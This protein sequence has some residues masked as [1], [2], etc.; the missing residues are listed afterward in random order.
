MLGSA[1]NHLITDDQQ[2]AM[3]AFSQHLSG[4]DV[5]DT[6]FRLHPFSKVAAMIHW[7]VLTLIAARMNERQRAHWKEVYGHGGQGELVQDKPSIGPK[8]F[9]AHFHLDRTTDLAGLPRSSSLEQVLR[10]AQA[11]GLV[12]A[13]CE[14][15]LIGTCA[16]FCDP[17]TYP[18]VDDL[19]HFPSNMALAIGL[20]PKYA[21]LNA[22]SPETIRSL[23][24]LVSR[25]RVRVFGE[26]GIDHSVGEDKWP[27]QKALLRKLL[28]LV[29]RDQVLLLHCRSSRPVTSIT[30]TYAYFDLLT[31]L[32]KSRVPQKLSIYLHC[33]TGDTYVLAKWL[34]AYPNTHFG[35]T[36][37]VR[38]FGPD[39]QQAL[40]EL[41]GGRV[42][43]ETDAPY[44]QAAK[45][46]WS[47]PSQLWD[48]AEA[49]AHVLGT[50]APEVLEETAQNAC[51]L[52]FGRE[53][54]P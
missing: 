18:T 4:S 30:I 16:S 10:H 28:P 21:G 20:H 33:F 48:I 8:A 25:P 32:I 35:F 27:I 52:F 14:V 50:I 44:F 11:K 3:A 38:S 26:V 7:R 51:L 2:Q 43:L 12:R 46:K 36:R 54:H 1:D 31:T 6:T 9:D 24:R 29:R 37:L 15:E 13:G 19:D 41:E 42:L 17:D 40:R 47:S 45:K 22:D 34:E 49:V 23:Q 5:L 53:H 39:Q